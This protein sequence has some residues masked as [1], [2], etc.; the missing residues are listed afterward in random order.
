MSDAGSYRR[1]QRY[2]CRLTQFLRR[3]TSRENYLM[4]DVTFSIASHRMKERNLDRPAIADGRFLPA[5]SERMI[6]KGRNQKT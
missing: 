6:T 1:L 2:P 4:D 5:F 3:K